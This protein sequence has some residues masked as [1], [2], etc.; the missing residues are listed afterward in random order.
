M[1]K[2]PAEVGAKERALAVWMQI[3]FMFTACR[4]PDQVCER[5]CHHQ[6]LDER[7][8]SKQTWEHKFAV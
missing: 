3:M 7:K 1:S 6:Y 5:V 8:W 4:H 2:S